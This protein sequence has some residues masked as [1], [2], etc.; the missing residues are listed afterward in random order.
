MDKKI[1]ITCQMTLSPKCKKTHE[2]WKGDFIRNKARNNNIYKC[3]ACARYKQALDGLGQKSLN[4]NMQYFENIDT[5]LKAY[6][7]GIIAGDG[8]MYSSHFRVVAHELDVETLRIFQTEISPGSKII[9]YKNIKCHYIDIPSIK[10]SLDICNILKIQPG[11]K[12]DIISLPDFNEKLTWHF[13]RGL[14]DS[15]GS[16]L[17]IRTSSRSFPVCSYASKSEII[18]NQIKKM[19]DDINISY[20]CDKISII[21]NGINAIKFM[22]KLYDGST[23]SLSRKKALYD[24]AKTWIPQKGSLFRPRKT[25]KDIGIKRGQNIC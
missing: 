23:I 13:I 11:K 24:M 12:S 20:T 14:M 8:S 15:D 22:N 2:M 3:S 17:D 1:T 5:E 21:F 9:K 16:I 18:K 7:L 6:M 10:L 25:R 4:K 19:C